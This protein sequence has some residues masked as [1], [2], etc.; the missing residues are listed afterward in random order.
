MEIENMESHLISIFKERSLRTDLVNI[1]IINPTTYKFLDNINEELAWDY[2]HWVCKELRIDN[3][4]TRS[5]GMSSE[6][7]SGKK[8]FGHNEEKKFEIS[9]KIVKKGTTKTDLVDEDGNSDASI[10]SGKKIQWGMHVMNRLPIRFQS[11]FQ[12]WFSTYTNESSLDN[13]RVYANQ[14]INE[15]ND[16]DK[17]YDLINWFFRGEENIPY[18]IVK[19]LKTGEYLKIGYDDLIRVLSDNISFRTSKEGKKP[20]IKIVADLPIGLGRKNTMSVFD[21]EPRTDKNNSLL[22]HG[23]SDVIIN[24]I[25]FYNIN[26]KEIYNFNGQEQLN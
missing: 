9:G 17:R 10:K 1:R 22:M 8:K 23:T 12:N 2:Y 6:Q 20:K 15:L 26:V 18:L 16:K 13:R 21:I 25:S 24:L 19:N 5:H 14:I 7:A 4:V 3:K 11:L